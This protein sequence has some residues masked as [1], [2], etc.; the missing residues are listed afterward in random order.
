MTIH[1][2]FSG[3]ISFDKNRIPPIMDNSVTSVK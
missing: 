1:I 3:F 2:L